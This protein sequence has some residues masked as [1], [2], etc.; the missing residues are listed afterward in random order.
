MTS[1]RDMCLLHY[2][3]VDVTVSH[4]SDFRQN[5]KSTFPLKIQ[6]RLN[7][8]LLQVLVAPTQY[9]LKNELRFCSK[10]YIHD[11]WLIIYDSSSTH[12]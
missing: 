12:F 2:N 11:K 1:S 5:S 10:M 4:S 7:L 6:I 8:L 3:H 9:E